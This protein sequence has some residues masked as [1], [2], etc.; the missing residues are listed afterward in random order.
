MKVTAEAVLNSTQ[1]LCPHCL[2]GMLCHVRTRW[3]HQ[4]S[5]RTWRWRCRECGARVNE[6]VYMVPREKHCA[7]G[8]D[9]T[10]RRRR[11]AGDWFWAIFG[12][13]PHVCRRCSKRRYR[14]VGWIKYPFTEPLAD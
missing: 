14:R 4:L 3:H 12:L 13:A 9:L 10:Y 11:G 1:P 7:C 8:C 2:S 6:Q 5:R